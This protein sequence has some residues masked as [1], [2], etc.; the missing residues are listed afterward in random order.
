MISCFYKILNVRKFP[1]GGV[2]PFGA[3]M[4][5]LVRLFQEKQVP[6]GTLKRS[7]RAPVNRG[8]R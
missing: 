7:C 5:E 3:S 2:T 8:R 6:R 4:I 1:F